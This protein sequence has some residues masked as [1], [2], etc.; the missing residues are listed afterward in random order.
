MT[1]PHASSKCCKP[2]SVRHPTPI[3]SRRDGIYRHGPERYWRAPWSWR[4]AID[5]SELKV[6][7]K[8]CAIMTALLVVITLAVK[9]A[10][11]AFTLALTVVGIALVVAL[12]A[13]VARN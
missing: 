4:Q 5:R 13:V 7:A 6:F 10:S 11:V 9:S 1:R 3:E 2:F 8:L 12:C